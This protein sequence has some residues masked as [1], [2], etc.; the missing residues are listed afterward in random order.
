MNTGIVGER[1]FAGQLI[2]T[3]AAQ[4]VSSCSL[5]RAAWN[6]CSIDRRFCSSDDWFTFISCDYVVG[7]R[8]SGID[9]ARSAER[10]ILASVIADERR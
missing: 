8:E 3:Y 1:K 5:K 6:R 4:P 7:I 10:S 9:D 2:A